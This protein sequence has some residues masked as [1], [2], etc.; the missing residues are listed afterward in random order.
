MKN[1]K[2]AS[3]ILLSAL[4][5]GQ[6]LNAKEKTTKLENLIVTAQKQEENVMNVPISLNYFSEFDIEQRDINDLTDIS[7]YT[8]SFEMMSNGTRGASTPSMRGIHAEVQTFQLSTGIYIDGVP[9]L[10]SVGYDTIFDDIESIQ[11]LRGPQSTL[12]GKNAEVGAIVIKTKQPTNEIQGKVQGTVGTDKKKELKLKVSGP[13]IKDKL[14]VGLSATRDEKKG[15]IQQ[16]STGKIIDDT[17]HKYYKLNLRSTPSDNLEMALISSYLK[18]DDGASRLNA[19]TQKDPRV[20][21]VDLVGSNKSKQVLNS[22]RIKYD[23]SKNTSIESITA[24]NKMTEDT[25]FDGDASIY[26]AFHTHRKSEHETSLQ[27]FRL[28]QKFDNF[29]YVLGLDFN[30]FDVTHK[31]KV[32]SYMLSNGTILSNINTKEE[33]EDKAKGVFFHSTYDINPKW[34]LITGLRYDKEDKEFQSIPSIIRPTAFNEKRSYSEFSP[35]L[36]LNYKIADNNILYGSVSKGYKPGGFNA[37]AP[38]GS[39]KT[40]TEEKILS[41]ELGNKLVLGKLALNTNIYHM[42]ITDMQVQE[43]FSPQLLVITNAAEA[44]SQ[45]LE[46]DL[47]Y[48]V[49]EA[50]NLFANAGFN[51]TKFDKFRDAL[52]DY[53]KNYNPNAPKYNYNLGL[54]Y[55]TPKGYYSRFDLNGQGKVYADKQNANS[56]KAFNTVDV[57]IGYE[58]ESYDIYLYSKNLFDKKYD[59]VGYHGG[60]Y[61][62]PSDP[63]E[64]GIKLTYRF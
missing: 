11:V 37:F 19:T 38:I 24:M 59:F 48:N 1:K 62:V 4:I 21:D 13:I 54:Q 29:R 27:E 9:S 25:V 6:G 35:K 16:K 41:Y 43:S 61:T 31:T 52:G 58:T 34:S 10:S 22:L 64:T 33:G 53:S 14:F 57:K 42:E 40:Y 17:G 39:P 26:P 15:F 60:N 36:A 8:P 32:L 20:M 30:K 55:R 23:F 63:R 12:Y 44:T 7:K 3:Y 47:N 49:N 51:R 5:L 2:A 28:N 45:G 18:Y 56:R 46:F 50:L